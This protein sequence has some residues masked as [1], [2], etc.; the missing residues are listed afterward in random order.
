MGG[1]FLETGI[2]QVFMNLTCNQMSVWQTTE[3]YVVL[4]AACIETAT[5]STTSS[6]SSATTETTVPTTST[7]ST[8]TSATTETV[9]ITSTT[10]TTSETTAED[11]CQSFFLMIT[12]YSAMC[13]QCPNMEA[14]EPPTLEVNQEIGML[15]LDHFFDYATGCRVVVVRC[16]GNSV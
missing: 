12:K 9:T 11:N 14:I 8:V 16:K 4:E 1:T 3:N 7:A 5:R 10:I 2:G 13:T 15:V 6:I